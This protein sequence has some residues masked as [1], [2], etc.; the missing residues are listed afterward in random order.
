MNT[1]E[2]VLLAFSGEIAKQGGLINCAGLGKPR[3][4]AFSASVFKKDKP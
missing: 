2:T 1:F 3:P 4:V